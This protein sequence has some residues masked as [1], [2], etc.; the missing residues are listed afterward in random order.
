MFKKW[1]LTKVWTIL[2]D[3]LVFQKKQKQK[4]KKKWVCLYFLLV[5]ISKELRKYN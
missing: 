1:F 4:Q 2:N 3:S 5:A